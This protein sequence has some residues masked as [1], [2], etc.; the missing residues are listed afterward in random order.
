M[1]KF[2]KGGK[3]GVPAINSGSLPDIIFML[4]F[5]FMVATRMKESKMQVEI[6]KPKAEMSVELEDKDNV[7]FLYIGFPIEVEKEGIENN[8]LISCRCKSTCL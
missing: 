4:L 7:D 2:R 6:L 1:S 3:K 8:L 5:F